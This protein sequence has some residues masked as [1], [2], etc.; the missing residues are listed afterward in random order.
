MQPPFLSPNPGAPSFEAIANRE[1][2]SEETLDTWLKDAHNY[3]DVM[4]FD[5]SPAQAEEIAQY[6]IT[7][8]RGDYRQVK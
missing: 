2:L 7:L 8:R 1:G 5:L 4:D 3:P 6:M